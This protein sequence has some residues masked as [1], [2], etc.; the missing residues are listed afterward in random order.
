MS[1]DG[2]GQVSSLIL[3]GTGLPGVIVITDL[4]MA[5]SACP[6]WMA[7]ERNNLYICGE[8]IFIVDLV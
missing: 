6:I 8:D 3:Q 4:T 7:Q 2:T 1:R 5:L